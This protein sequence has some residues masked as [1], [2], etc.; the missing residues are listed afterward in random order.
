M[1]KI[2][3][4]SLKCDA[5]ATGI[6]LLGAGVLGAVGSVFGSSKAKQSSDKAAELAYKGQQETNETNLNIVRETNAANLQLAQHQNQWNIE[7]WIRENQYNSPANQMKLYKQAGLN[8]NL[9]QG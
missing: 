5:V 6:G 8:P 1:R 9:E 4:P 3:K 7:Q 2:H